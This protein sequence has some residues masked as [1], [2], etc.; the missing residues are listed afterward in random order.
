MEVMKGMKIVEASVQTSN[1][2]GKIISLPAIISVKALTRSVLKCKPLI[3]THT[4]LRI[5]LFTKVFSVVSIKMNLMKF[6]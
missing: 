4:Q 1:L 6:C 5:I 2:R 3:N